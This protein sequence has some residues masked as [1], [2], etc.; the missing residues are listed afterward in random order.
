MCT[1]FSKTIPRILQYLTLYKKFQCLNKYLI[2]E[3]IVTKVGIILFDF[4][5]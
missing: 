4:L 5:S 1:S 2:V 3:S